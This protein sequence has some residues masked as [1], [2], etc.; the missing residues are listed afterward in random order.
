MQFVH[1]VWTAMA[2]R[3]QE[4]RKAANSIFGNRAIL[5]TVQPVR[6]QRFWGPLCKWTEGT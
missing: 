3:K 4:I 1:C 6:P 2:K 5:R